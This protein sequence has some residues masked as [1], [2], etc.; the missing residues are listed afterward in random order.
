[1]HKVVAVAQGA[2]PSQPATRHSL[3]I[4]VM[5]AAIFDSFSRSTHS[6]TL[7]AQ[8]NLNWVFA[9]LG[10]ADAATLSS[11][12]GM[13]EG[14]AAPDKPKPK[15]ICCACPETKVNDALIT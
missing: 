7:H 15:K 10:L 9:H 14:A 3:S 5:H 12:Q 6:L 1:M 4:F 13:P 11:L 8:Q 2:R